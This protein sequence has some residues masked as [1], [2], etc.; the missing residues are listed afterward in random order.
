[1]GTIVGMVVLAAL[2]VLCYWPFFNS[3]KALFVGLGIS[4]IHTDFQPF[5]VM[6]GFF[7]FVGL[8]FIAGELIW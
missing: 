2:S 6:W 1:M 7:L 3:Y 5:I 4:D 8:S